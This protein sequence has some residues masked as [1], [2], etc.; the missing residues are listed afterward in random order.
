MN[1]R[2]DDSADAEPG[3]DFNSKDFQE[4]LKKLMSG[5]T[6]FD[7][8]E[9]AAAAG[10]PNDPEGLAQIMRQLQTAMNQAGANAEGVNW[11]LASQQA[12]ELA[13]TSSKPVDPKFREELKAAI[14]IGSLWLNQATEISDL[15][16]EPKVLSRELWVED[17]M[18]LFQALAQPVADRMSQALTEN[19]KENAPEELAG[20][21]ASAD[22][23][24]RSAGGALFAMQLGQA[25]GKLS[26]E[27]ITGG[28]IGLP[29][30]QD[31]RAAF[32]AQN[33]DSFVSGLD[34]ERDQAFIYLSV[35]ELAHVRLFKHSKWLRDHVV[36]QISNYAAG[37]TIDNSKL[38]GLAE[39]FAGDGEE[40]RRALESGALIAE[41][42]EDQELALER[43]ETMLA[44]IEGWV[45]VVTESATKLLPRAA[46]IAE[47]VRRRRATG[48]PAEQTFG[49]LIGLQ[50]R[51]KRLREAA[52]MWRAIGEAVGNDKRDS[53]WDHPDLVP[54]ADDINDPS[55]LI[56]KLNRTGSETDSMDDEL[57][58]MLDEQG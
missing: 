45:D 30:F 51:P 49:T 32:V 47:A 20:I 21:L 5:E 42:T 33:F 24:F 14:S 10:L 22:G 53:L 7:P 50:L 31:Q 13:K 18:P 17:A 36:S 19:L 2:F 4:F 55:G 29:I 38:E 39:G 43:I 9:L 34:V 11:G 54:S 40:I 57:R 56:S 46:A 44:L 37:I 48:G 25:L 6:G 35:R 27:V 8:A 58:R 23:L 16:A 3:R 12:K 26:A 52:A 15:T 1:D 28:D 41:R